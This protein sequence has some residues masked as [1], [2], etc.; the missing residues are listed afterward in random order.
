MDSI[1]FLGEF[2]HTLDPKGRV[3]VPKKFLEALP[4]DEPRVLFVTKGLDGCLTLFT[5]SA[6]KSTVTEMRSK[7]EGDAQTRH[8]RRVF[9]SLASDQSIDGSGRILIPERLRKEAGL[10][11]EVIFVGMVDRI[12]L[13]DKQRWSEVFG[14]ISGSYE[15]HAKEVLR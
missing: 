11:R 6:W 10:D 8:F 2:T 12:E 5:T 4:K 3:F 9:F 15:D 1:G 14:E 7:P 13:W